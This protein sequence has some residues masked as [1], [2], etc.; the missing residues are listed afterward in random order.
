MPDLEKD[1]EQKNLKIIA[2]NAKKI[3]A[4]YEGSIIEISLVG[5]TITLK[6]GTF[7]LS[8]YPQLKAVIDH[9][10]Q[11]LHLG[12]YSTIVNS[13]KES[14]DLSNEKNDL[15]VDKRLAGKK[16]TANGERI[17][18][19]TNRGAL[20]EFIKRKEKGMNLSDRV[21]N[22]LQPFKSQ[23]EGGLAIGISEGKSAA[24]MARDLKSYLNDPDKLFR[25]V[26]DDNGNLQLSKAAKDFHP[27]RGVYRSSYRNALRLTA[28]ETNIAYN[29]ADQERWL[30][31]PFVI[32]LKIQTSH[33]HPEYDICDEL[34]GVYP[35]TFVWRRWHPFC[36]CFQTAV[37]LS[38]EEYEKYEDKIL[39]G[40]PLPEIK[41]ITDVPKA[42]TDYVEKNKDRIEGY[43]SKPYW[44]KDNKQYHEPKPVKVE[45]PV[46]SFT[47]AKSIE[48]AE[49]FAEKHFIKESEINR[50][51]N[52]R[53]DAA[54]FL[55]KYP[56]GKIQSRLKTVDF[57]G[58]PLDVANA[59][60]K[61]VFEE[62]EFLGGV[63]LNNLDAKI[64]RKENWTARISQTGSLEL[65]TKSYK[66]LGIVSDEENTVAE[67]KK[68]IPTLEKLQ[69]EGRLNSSQQMM[70]RQAQNIIKYERA[71]V[72]KDN[73]E[74]ITH[75]MGHHLDNNLKKIASIK[76]KD[77]ELAFEKYKDALRESVTD[78][79]K[80]KISYYAFSNIS[81]IRE[82]V[83]AE[84]YTL[85]RKGM[86]DKLSPKTLDFFN[87]IFK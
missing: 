42:F 82:E 25:R 38:D 30:K 32:G 3:K 31:M 56:T 22:S 83:F 71:T 18:Y 75:E 52:N 11:K 54:N 12:I 9:E 81:A 5:S 23:L 41:G 16:P 62:M 6:E 50:I 43:K 8:K 60:N 45:A 29:A 67:F 48:E 73:L 79:Y 27:G 72:S 49:A 34:A 37:Q 7:L 66:K 59:V 19:D 47:P 2:R 44:Y 46:R 13:V 24:S 64:V 70:Y 14:W 39:A 40:E 63:K 36:I 74:V 84:T 4:L 10:L 85:Y 55:E 20:D 53:I 87:Y 76:G 51:A 15:I 77:P 28:T 80:Y 33:N 26:R 17:L 21:W 35:K 68:L 58:I 78:E 69:A 57:R 61:Q 1:F 86:L 65:N